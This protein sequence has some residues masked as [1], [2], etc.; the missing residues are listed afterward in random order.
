MLSS[1]CAFTHLHVVA[2]AFQYYGAGEK[3]WL[4]VDGDDSGFQTDFL[5]QGADPEQI[6]YPSSLQANGLVAE[7]GAGD[8]FYLA[9]NMAHAV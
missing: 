9:P 3:I 5:D 6:A 8:F 7:I 1:A 4:L 2:V